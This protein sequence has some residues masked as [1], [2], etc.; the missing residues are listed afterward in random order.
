MTFDFAEMVADED[1][2]RRALGDGDIVTLAM[3]LVQLTGEVD[4]LDDVAPFVRGPFD[5]SVSMPDDKQDAIRE[6]LIAVLKELAVRAPDLPSPPADLL[7]RMMSTC[8]G[9]TVPDE[10]VPMMVEEL[11]FHDADPKGVSW[12]R[13]PPPE[14]LERFHV[15][16]IGAGMSGLCAA[17]KLKQAGIPFTV[18]EKNDTVGGTWYENRYPGCGVDTPNHFYS[19][20]F[21]PSHQWTQF[22]SKRDELHAYLEG[23]ADKYD[24]RRHI[25]FETT[26]TAARYDEADACWRLDLDDGGGRAEAIEANA[27]ISAV[28]QLNRP[29]IPDIDGLADFAG[30][31]FHTGHWES[32]HDLAGR[33]VA[34][35]GTGA[36]GVQAGPSIAG[37]VEHLTVFQRTPHWIVANPNYHRAVS[38]G[39]QWVLEHLPFYS[40]WY[41]FQLF[42]GFSDGIHAALQKDP[43]WD[44]PERSLNQTNERFRHFMVRHAERQIGDDADLLAKVIPPYPPYGKRMLIDNHWYAMLKR[45]NVD[46]VTEP[47]DHVEPDAVVTGDGVRHPADMIIMATGF[48]AARMLAP[49]DI[50][51]RGGRVLRD[52]WGDEDPRAYLGMTMPGFPNFFVLYGPN[53][54]LGHGG[55]IMFHT[56]CQVRY[57]MKCLRHL[58]EGGHGSMECRAEIHD[59]F[60][61]RVDAAHENMVWT[62]PGTDNWYRNSKGRVITNS[63]WRL[64]DYWTMTETPE[65]DDFIVA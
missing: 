39:K 38:A 34:L 17:I 33:R 45:D 55:S 4:L 42:W 53:T 31:A 40:R 21:E 36:S 1:H 64:V 60:N 11:A 24:I 23:C 30:P 26:V 56:E 61:A 41:R 5:Y 62:H 37:D 54:N 63:P 50:V 59:A 18:I 12:R 51:G 65:L 22:Y 35:I 25:R 52:D 46:L 2:L 43:D 15:A 3:V 27:I 20:S 28:G 13:P 7:Q 6:R 14:V 9:E 49:M 58:I 57:V 32:E 48:Q 8:V 19:F 44:R 10:Y 16:V 29:A 47:I